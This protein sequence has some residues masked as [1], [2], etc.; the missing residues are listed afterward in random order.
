ME[1]LLIENDDGRRFLVKIDKLEKTELKD[2]GPIV[3]FF[4]A[5]YMGS[6]GF[7]EYGQFVSSYYLKTLL[8]RHDNEGLD[9]CGYEPVWKIDA[10]TMNKIVKFLNLFN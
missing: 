2:H 9:L 7:T 1:A 5:E 3:K 10:A 8:D 4:D 6:P